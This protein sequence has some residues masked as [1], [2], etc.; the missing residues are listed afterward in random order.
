MTQLTVLT[1]PAEAP[2]SLDAVKAFLRIGDTADDALL[3]DLLQS[4]RERLEQVAGLALVQQT[5]RVV[6]RRWPASIR[7]RGVRLPIG[8]VTH[9]E[10]VRL[11]DDDDVAI[12][13]R[14]RFQLACER[15]CLRPWSPLPPVY[16]RQ[17]IEVDLAV[18]FGRAS[19]IPEDLQ[20]ALLRLIAAIYSARAPGLFEVET[21]ALPSGVQ[22]IL[23]ARKEVRL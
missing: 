3:M 8:P 2:L 6:W 12:D 18:G 22:A 16:D 5:V 9:V 14:E 4:A 1:P 11:V 10:A 19:D 23:D 15:L 13:Y 7:G 17:R 21:D 20:E